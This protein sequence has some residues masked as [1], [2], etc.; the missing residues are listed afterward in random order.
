MLLGEVLYI[1]HAKTLLAVEVGYDL[2]YYPCHNRTVTLSKGQKVMF[3][4]EW[5]GEMFNLKDLIPKTFESCSTCLKPLT[6]KQCTLKHNSEARKITGVWKVVYKRQ[7]KR[8]SRLFLEQK[9]FTFAVTTFPGER[10]YKLFRKIKITDHVRVSGWLRERLTLKSI[11]R[12]VWVAKY[13]KRLFE[14]SFQ[15]N[16][17]AR[18]STKNR[19]SDV[20]QSIKEE[21]QGE[22][23]PFLD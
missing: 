3:T 15:R 19:S 6:S 21:D 20:A 7:D 13:P 23:V 5:S 17:S 16:C 11:R 14:D 4:G 1:S 10:H 12:C 2:T 8:H 9:R 22:N 18:Y